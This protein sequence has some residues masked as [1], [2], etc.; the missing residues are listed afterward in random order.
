MY[1]WFVPLQIV[2][3]F[4][5][6]NSSAIDNSVWITC[7]DIKEGESIAFYCGDSEGSTLEF[8]APDDW[9]TRDCTVFHMNK[10]N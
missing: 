2:K 4:T 8:K 9:R 1:P 7:L 6:I 5:S 10:K 3:D